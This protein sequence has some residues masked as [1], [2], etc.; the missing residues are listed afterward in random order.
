MMDARPDEVAVL[1]SSAPLFG[2]TRSD[3]LQ[4]YLTPLGPYSGPIPRTLWRS[5]GGGQFLMS[6]VPL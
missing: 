4:G 2:G 6:E 5:W 3:R 1:G